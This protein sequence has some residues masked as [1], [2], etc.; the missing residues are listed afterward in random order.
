V[1]V[2]EQGHIYGLQNQGGGE[3]VLKFVKSLPEDDPTNHD[4]TLCQEVLRALVNRVLDL[5]SQKPH[6]NNIE[7]ITKL[8]EC[9]LLFESRAFEET[10][11]KSYAKTGLYIEQL[12]TEGNGHLYD[13]RRKESP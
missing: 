9:L 1:R 5:N 6:H 13:P 12:P 8:R 11:K 10:V 4:G 7:I 3:Q 2:I